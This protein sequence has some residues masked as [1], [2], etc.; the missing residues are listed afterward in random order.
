MATESEL[1]QAVGKERRAKYA[2]DDAWLEL[3]PAK[4]VMDH[5]PSDANRKRL[6]K[7][8]RVYVNKLN[9]YKKTLLSVK[10]ILPPQL[11]QSL[12]NSLPT[13]S[14]AYRLVNPK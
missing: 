4:Y 13:L 5:M 10:N 11:Y 1:L 14:A 12:W 3:A 8:I 6:D 9:A 2:V 7:R